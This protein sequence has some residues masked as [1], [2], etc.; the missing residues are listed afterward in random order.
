MVI[1]FE[2]FVSETKQGWEAGEIWALLKLIREKKI[3]KRNAPLY[4]K[5][6]VVK[7]HGP[8]S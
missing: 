1:S 2:V 5:L 7:I 8:K 3:Y 6:S 4:C